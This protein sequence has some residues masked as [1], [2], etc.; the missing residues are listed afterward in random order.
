[1]STNFHALAV[2][3][4]LAVAAR[5]GVFA[6]LADGPVD[7]DQ[8]AASLSLQAEP[9]RMMLDVLVGD[10]LLEYLCP[11]YTLS[12]G[13]RRWLD[14][15]SPTAIT[16]LLS[17][18]LDYW[19][20]WTDLERVVRGGDV[21]T[22]EPD[23]G[24]E[25]GWLRR[26]RGEYE[27][28]RLL[29]DSV[30]MTVGLPA[31]ARSV[32]DLGGGHGWY[33][34]ALCRR[35]PRLRATVIDRAGAVR[36]GREIMWETDMDRVVSHQVGDIYTSDLG[37]PHDAAL[38]WPLM[39]EPS[40]RQTELLLG[41]IRRALAPKAVLA[42]MRVYRGAG[43]TDEPQPAMAAALDLFRCLRSGGE[44]SEPGQ[45]ETTLIAA[46]FEAPR[47]HRLLSNRNL[48]VYVT[49]VA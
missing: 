46:G 3:R 48:C 14:P 49:R 23:D 45:L 37:G 5:T 18:L 28:A 22:S 26:T 32:L 31:S 25:A 44:W 43:T 17:H 30:A 34:A 6:A 13:A 1:M 21:V 2:A 8:L 19:D 11:H 9:L 38:C 36:I 12:V 35:N 10:G 39:F 16:T 41:R 29:A 15:E 4:T 7:A 33:A 24:D 47:V 20:T 40:R 27:L 42:I